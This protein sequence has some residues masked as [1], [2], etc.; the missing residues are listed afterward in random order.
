MAY[1]RS[2]RGVLPAH[3]RHCFAALQT[4]HSHGGKTC[5]ADGVAWGVTS[6][7]SRKTRVTPARS[8]WYTLSVIRAVS[9][10]MLTPWGWGGAG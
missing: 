6:A 8:T 5:E 2:V 1:P 7:F 3:A 9:A 10:L 4:G